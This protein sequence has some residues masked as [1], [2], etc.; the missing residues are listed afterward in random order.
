MG[1]P[2]RWGFVGGLW[3]VEGAGLSLLGRAGSWE[4]WQR[5]SSLLGVWKQAFP[6][7]SAPAILLVTPVHPGC[8]RDGGSR[9]GR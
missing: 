7:W 3:A 5:P 1:K 9:D 6:T 8:S 2:L 4:A